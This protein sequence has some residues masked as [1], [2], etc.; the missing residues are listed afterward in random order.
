MGKRDR[1]HIG[2]RDRLHIGKRDR[3]HMG[4]RDGLQ[5]PDAT[6]D[7][8]AGGGPEKV[9]GSPD[10]GR[11][12]TFFPGDGASAIAFRRDMGYNS[13]EIPVFGRKGGIQP[14]PWPLSYRFSMR[15]RACWPM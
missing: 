13:P 2:K 9:C 10:E 4:K 1:V 15:K 3:L 5:F 12:P 6:I 8:E 7:D 14:C 11:E